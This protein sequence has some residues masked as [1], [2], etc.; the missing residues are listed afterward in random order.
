[1]KILCLSKLIVYI[2]QANNFEKCSFIFVHLKM[3]DCCVICQ[4][5]TTFMKILSDAEMRQID[6]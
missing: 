5:T 3:E 6:Y 1:M 4:L 2:I